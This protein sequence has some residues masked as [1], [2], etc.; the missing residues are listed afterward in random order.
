MAKKSKKSK[1]SSR[2]S[3]SSVVRHDGRAH[4]APRDESVFPRPTVQA[5]AGHCA[6]L[7]PSDSRLTSSENGH[8]WV[9]V[10]VV[11]QDRQRKHLGGANQQS[12]RC[13]QSKTSRQRTPIRR[14]CRRR[15][16][17]S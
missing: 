17:D 13:A 6:T 10:N 14:K 12:D 3:T 11:A 15:G 1:K 16:R 5:G 7:A 8:V 2:H 9:V 4:D